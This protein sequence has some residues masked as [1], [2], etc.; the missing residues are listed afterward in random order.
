MR[1]QQ[2]IRAEINVTPLVDVCLVLLVI[3]MVITP[4]MNNHGIR[5][6][7]PATTQPAQKSDDQKELMLTINKDANVFIES[8]SVSR[9]ELKQRLTELY[10]RNPTKQIWI[11]ADETLAY[12]EV[13][14][15]MQT[16]Q[17]AGFENMSLITQRSKSKP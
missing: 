9:D 16:V 15:T 8:D 11:R 4:L 1:E 10:Q 14:A 5:V 7:L 3:F 17:Q 13:K 12:K 2:E 6:S